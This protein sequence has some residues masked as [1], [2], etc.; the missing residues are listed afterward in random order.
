VGFD[1]A[2]QIALGRPETGWRPGQAQFDAK[3]NRYSLNFLGLGQCWRTF[4]RVRVQA[5]DNFRRTSFARANLRLLA[6]YFRLFQ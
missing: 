3:S 4:L 1:V 6:L 5:A 2:D